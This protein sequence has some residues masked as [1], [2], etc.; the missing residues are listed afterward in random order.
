MATKSKPLF[1]SARRSSPRTRSGAVPELI[2]S[3]RT[4]SGAVPELICLP[5]TRSGAVPE[6]ISS[7]RTRSGA[8]PELI[9]SP[10]TFS[11]FVPEPNSSPRTDGIPRTPFSSGAVTPVVGALKSVSLSDWWLTKKAN[12]KALGVTGF[13]SKGGYEV[14]LFS[15]G[16]ISIRHDSTTLETSDGIRVCI[17]GFINRSRTLQNGFSSEVC[18]RFLLGFPYSWKDHDEDETVEE[19]KHFG[20]SFDDIPVNRYEDLLFTSSSCLKSEI[21]DDVVNSLRDLVCPRTEKSNEE[22]EKSRMITE[23]D[24]DESVVPSVVGVKTRGMLRRS[25]ENE[26]SIGKRVHTS[27]KRRR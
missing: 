3:P 12:E 8:V 25:E 10:R 23:D 17:S 21:L 20:I 5:R 1:L 22:C 18:N 16:T 26:A 13:E 6:L 24:D 2:S 15:S 27:S 9:S 7:P 14:R 19:K 4:R 11:K